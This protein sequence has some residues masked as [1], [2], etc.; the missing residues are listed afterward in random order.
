MTE[1][2][3][4]APLSKEAGPPLTSEGRKYGW[5]IP[6]LL[7]VAVLLAMVASLCIGAY[8]MSFFRA[9]RIVLHL[10]WPFALPAHPPWNIKDSPWY[11][12]SDC[13]GYC[14]R[15]SQAWGLAWR[16]RLSRA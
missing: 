2:T 1:T 6:V 8:P 16:E 3:M 15:R 9:A 12:S 4:T 11:S 14:S 10:A 7:A 13:P 5:A